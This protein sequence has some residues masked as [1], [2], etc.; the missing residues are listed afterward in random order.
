MVKDFLDSHKS[1]PS[2]HWSLVYR[3]GN[4]E[5][6][7]EILGGLLTQYFPALKVHLVRGR[8]LRPD[9][10]DDVL[11][12]FVLDKFMLDSLLGHADHTRGRF[13]TFL[14]NVLDNYLSNRL[15]HERAQSRSP[16]KPLESIDEKYALKSGDE[17]SCEFELEWAR[18]LVARAM[19]RME[20]ECLSLGRKDIWIAFEERVVKPALGQEDGMGY[21]DL[22]AK[23]HFDSPSQ[24][25]NALAT[26]KRAYMRVLR[27][28][29]AEY[30]V[31][32]AEIEEELLD[33]KRIL[34]D[35]SA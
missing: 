16:G 28:V 5:G 4:C 1:F 7:K 3:A 33:L 19:K 21:A 26:G 31:N 25:Y 12:G 15:R 8:G 29:I 24:A 23:G 13:R 6:A 34:F 18:Q 17:V 2:T 20:E 22:V 35:R 9:A 10:A 11:Q 32:E 14:L 30:A 27:Q